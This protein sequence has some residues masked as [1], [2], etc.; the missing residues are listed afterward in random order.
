M[1]PETRALLF[2]GRNLRLVL[3]HQPCPTNQAST[4]NRLTATK[5]QLCNGSLLVARALVGYKR[6]RP[7]AGCAGLG[8]AG[9]E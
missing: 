3:K 9:V 8:T 5:H 6:T 1:F 4:M 7:V 2:I